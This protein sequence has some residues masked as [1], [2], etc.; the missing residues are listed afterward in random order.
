MS[1]LK[2]VNELKENNEDYEF[3]PTTREIIETLY[4]DINGPLKTEKD[5]RADALKI[6]LLDIGAGNCKLYNTFKEI[7]ES[8]PILNE[9]FY[10]TPRDAEQ[11]EKLEIKKVLALKEFRK[12]MVV[13]L[14]DGNED[15]ED[16][17]HFDQFMLMIPNSKLDEIDFSDLEYTERNLTATEKEILFENIRNYE[18]PKSYR[19]E[20]E[21]L[22]NRIYFE[23]YM[24]IE[25]S[26]TLIDNMP[27]NVFV[28]GTDF[29]ENTLIDKKTDYVFCNPP[30]SEYSQWTERIIKEANA[31]VIYFVIPKR[32]GSQGNIAHAIKQRRATV[33]IVGDFDFLESEDRKARAKVS[34]VK[35][36][37][38]G[39]EKLNYRGYKSQSEEPLIDPFNLWFNE[40]FKINA[41]QTEEYAYQI[42]E[43]KAKEHKENVKNA[44]VN[45]SDLVSSLVEL[46]NRDLTKLTTNYL[47]V[48]ELDADI[49]KE[50]NVDVKNLLNAF[51][52]KIEGLKNLYWQEIFNNLDSITTRLTS[53]TRESLLNTL[54]SNTN[55]DFTTGNIR[56]VVIWVIKNSSKYFNS[57]MLEVYNDF[58]TGEG[59]KLYKSNANFMNDNWRYCRSEKDKLGK[60][61]LDYRIV[62]HGYRS[63]NSWD[64]DKDI[65]SDAQKQYIKDIVII[66]KNLGFIIDGISYDTFT[67]KDKHNTTFNPNRKEP[68]KVGS[69]TLYGKIEEVYFQ[70]HI[71]NE[72]GEDVME[73]DGV[74]YVYREDQDS[75]YYQYKIKSKHDESSFYLH[76]NGIRTENDIFTTVRGYS[77]GNVH[78][79]F[80]QEFIKKLNLEVGRL[81]GWIKTPQ[82]A[83]EEFDITLEEANEYWKSTYELLPSTL[84]HLLPQIKKE[85]SYTIETIKNDEIVVDVRDEMCRIESEMYLKLIEDL[86]EIYDDG[87]LYGKNGYKGSIGYSITNHFTNLTEDYKS[88]KY[89]GLSR[90]VIY[91]NSD[92][93]RKPIGLEIYRTKFVDKTPY[94]PI[95]DSKKLVSIEDFEEFVKT[96]RDICLIEELSYKFRDLINSQP[97]NSLLLNIETKNVTE[98][99]I[100]E[101]NNV[102]VKFKETTIFDYL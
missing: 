92:F 99:E 52:E 2:L 61:A 34:L 79:Q 65:L 59:I 5:Y 75:S 8:Q 31:K 21:R 83:A 50:L 96:N 24:A 100:V 93:K 40:T 78:F 54:M 29:N 69:K 4:W 97:K 33:S 66:A 62:C 41:K 64:R 71:P 76:E 49:L 17:I 56:S 80:N 87:T 35:I 86:L 53:R 28:V 1:A 58:T 63:N 90:S 102:E 70:S 12:R 73:K 20:R 27:N 91:T 77:N 16:E 67:L 19:S 22:A 85:P 6:S 43:Q 37:L 42:R 101:I 82:E 38:R 47:K 81:R 60:Y 44:L 26:Q 72:N 98:K 68:L 25:K 84:S 9:Y 36:D 7:A 11:Y 13:I 10:H 18:K 57:Q 39:K 32:W 74:I 94:V 95:E 48:S 51:K 14:N 46:Y 45:G 30:Y 88:G 15:F 55:I 89:E 3:Y 23:K